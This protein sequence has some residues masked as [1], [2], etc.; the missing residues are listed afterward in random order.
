VAVSEF[1][2]KEGNWALR[3]AA[4]K[5]GPS[6]GTDDDPQICDIYQYSVQ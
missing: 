3:V 1:V 6:P 5:G 2:G 4:F